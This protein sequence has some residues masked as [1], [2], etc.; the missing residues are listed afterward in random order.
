MDFVGLSQDA[1]DAEGGSEGLMH[2]LMRD[3]EWESKYFRV[4]GRRLDVYPDE[5]AVDGD[6]YV[7]KVPMDTLIVNTKYFLDE[8]PNAFSISISDQARCAGARAR[9]S[10][11]AAW[12]AAA[13]ESSP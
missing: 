1:E 2:L 3:G 11:C 10:D 7:C 13:A 4:R 6:D 8:R 12:K 5:G 9:P